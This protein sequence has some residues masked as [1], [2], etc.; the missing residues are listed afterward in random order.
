MP[1]VGYYVFSVYTCFLI[2][3][4]GGDAMAKVSSLVYG[5]GNDTLY[6]KTAI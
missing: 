3:Q 4:K 2:K 5:H 1:W 6:Q